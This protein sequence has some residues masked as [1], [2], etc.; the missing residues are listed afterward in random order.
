MY[1]GNDTE[2]V[3][4]TEDMSPE[5]YDE[6]VQYWEE[7]AEKRAEE[8]TVWDEISDWIDH[9]FPQCYDN[10]K[11]ERLLGW[12]VCRTVGD[13]QPVQ[14]GEYKRHDENTWY[15]P[16]LDFLFPNRY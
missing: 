12:H 6:I 13:A 14:A 16:L 1:V 11:N 10:S 15:N 5:E 7:E 3:I 4:V 2:V 9:K 8:K